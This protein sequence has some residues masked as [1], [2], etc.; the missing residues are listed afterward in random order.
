MLCGDFT[1]A[2]LSHKINISC[3]TPDKHVIFLREAQRIVNAD[4]CTFLVSSNVK[5]GYLVERLK[6]LF[7]SEK[8]VFGTCKPRFPVDLC[9][10]QKASHLPNYS[11]CFCY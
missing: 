10:L 5:V 4:S 6:G 2:S 11:N 7:F 8:L 9:S 1:I 3:Q